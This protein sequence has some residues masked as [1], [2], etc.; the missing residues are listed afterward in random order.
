M[1][2]ALASLVKCITNVKTMMVHSSVVSLMKSVKF[3]TTLPRHFHG[4]D[5]SLIYSW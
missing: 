4:C 1:T 2:I 5:L 3:T